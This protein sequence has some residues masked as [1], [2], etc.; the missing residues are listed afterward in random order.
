MLAAARMACPALSEKSV[1]QTMVIGLAPRN[2]AARLLHDC[3]TTAAR[4]GPVR[5]LLRARFTC[6]PSA[7]PA[8][9][10][11]SSAVLA[12]AIASD[13][14]RVEQFCFGLGF[15]ILEHKP[16]EFCHR[17]PCSS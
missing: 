2:A 13:S 16:N 1:P 3:Y 6:V 12:A 5:V 4:T 7:R 17:S 14:R 11:R 10:L 9:V 15:A 8:H